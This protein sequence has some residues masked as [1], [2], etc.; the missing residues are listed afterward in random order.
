MQDQKI[1]ILII[2]AHPDDADV[3]AGGTAALWAKAGYPVKFVSVTNGDAGH[4]IETRENLT[5]RRK[6]ESE[7]AA[8]RLGIAAYQLL[9]YHDTELLPTLSARHQIIRLIR[10]W[11]ADLVITHRPNDYHPDHRYTSML[12]QD[13][14]YLV[15]VP[16]VCPDTPVLEKNPVFLYLED[17]FKKPNPFQPDI[18][19]GI[20]ETV[21][22]KIMALDAHVSQFYEW[23]PW[24]EERGK[25]P[26][27]EK[28]R[29]TYLKSR[30]IRKM[31][32]ATRQSLKKW[33]GETQGTAI[34]DAESFEICEYGAQPTMAEIKKL[35]PMLP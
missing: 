2:G 3:K 15:S 27:D 23:L 30:W 5:Q 21:E 34:Q 12:V 6:A 7:E 17:T 9:D 20:D 11:K 35:F 31:S 4:H 1:N 18:A 14:A 33:Y 28:A 32:N 24:I 13:A 10:E 29:I 26:S 25:A 19:I 8:R 16:H 22:Q